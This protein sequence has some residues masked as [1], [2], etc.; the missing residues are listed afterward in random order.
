[1]PQTSIQQS[2]TVR[3]GSGKF[4]IGDSVGS[5]VNVG[6]FRGGKFEETY[7]KVS[8]MSDNAG[9]VYAGIKNH[10][11]ILSCELIEVNLDVLAKVNKG[12][13]SVALNTTTPVAI[14]DESVTLNGVVGVRLANKSASGAIVTSVTVTHASGTPTYTRGTD[15]ELIVDSAGY[16]VIARAGTGSPGIADG[17]TVLVDYTY[18]PAANRLYKSGGL[19]Q[20]TPQVVRF[21]NTR[22]SDDKKFEITVFKAT[23][24]NGIALEFPADDG[25]D[26]LRTPISM[27]GTCLTSR[28]AGDQLFEI[29]DEQH[30]T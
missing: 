26:V 5:L 25:D 27:E 8:V 21:T 24:A 7:E 17:Q 15:Y 28:T 30:A 2:N 9:E 12:L 11:A 3:F 14:T 13:S 18:T 22:V 4:E 19:V 10:K 16:T 1:M 6:A 20:L 29:L 23:A